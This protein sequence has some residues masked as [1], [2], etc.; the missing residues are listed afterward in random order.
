MERRR[1]PW[2][3]AFAAFVGATL[4]VPALSWVLLSRP[5]DFI[6]FDS[7]KDPHHDHFMYIALTTTTRAEVQ[8]WKGGRWRTVGALTSGGG[9]EPGIAPDDVQWAEYTIPP[10][11]RGLRVRVIVRE[12]KDHDSDLIIALHDESTAAYSPGL[13]NRRIE[14]RCD[15]PRHVSPFGLG[16]RHP[17]TL[18]D[19]RGIGW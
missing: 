12:D 8:V 2:G 5:G 4:A 17:T 9:L 15:H 13:R 3:A 18:R 10:S 14:E 11:F 19:G 6:A 16:R 7:G 1:T